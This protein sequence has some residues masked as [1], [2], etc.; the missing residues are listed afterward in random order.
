MS[1]LQSVALSPSYRHGSR[2]GLTNLP[3][4]YFY[5]LGTSHSTRRV[6]CQVILDETVRTLE[7]DLRQTSVSME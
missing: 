2:I 1:V 4:A 3:T 6:F 5:T 7:G